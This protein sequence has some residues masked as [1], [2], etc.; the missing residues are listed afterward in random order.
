[1]IEENLSAA[2]DRHRAMGRAFDV[3]GVKSFVRDEG[4][5]PA[6]LFVH[7]MW[8]ASYLYRKLVPELAGRG[9]RA[10]VFDLPGFGFAARPQEF[11]YT[12]TGLGSFAAAAVDALQLNEIHVVVHD[13][14]GPVGFELVSRLPDRVRSLTLLNTMVDVTGF[15]PPWSMRPFR[16]RGAGE[17]W[18]RTLNRPAFRLLMRMQGVGDRSAVSPAELDAYLE[19][20]RLG[21]RGRGFLRTMRGAERSAAKQSLYRSVVSSPRYPVELIWAG[22]DPALRMETYG[23]QAAAVAGAE[24]QVIPGK[25]FPQ[26]DQ[27]R[28]ISDSL[29]RF[30]TSVE[31]GS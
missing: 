24:P 26:E 30:V 19:L 3:N 16:R 27:W 10:I 31:A 28:P 2:L 12:W 9:M 4:H 7:G 17:L 22:D 1:M 8:G 20:M 5:G 18:L 21:D 13:I 6:V 14:G 11:D 25:H 15:N 29:A 23:R